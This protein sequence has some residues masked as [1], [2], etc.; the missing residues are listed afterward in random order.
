MEPWVKVSQVPEEHTPGE[1]PREYAQRLAQS[2]GRAVRQGLTEAE[3]ASGPAW[4]L[5]ADTVVVRGAHLLEKPSDEEDARRILRAL[6]GGWHEVVTAFWLGSVGGEVERL[7]FGA[8]RVQFREMDED[9]VARYVATGEPMDKAGAYG[10]QG[11]AGAFVS[12]I[13]GSYFNVVGLPT[14]QVISALKEAGAL[15][16]FPFLPRGATP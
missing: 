14:D 13:E 3:R 2:K 15:G 1:A 11:L 10:I 6:S 5:A 9:E 7:G 12:R 4:I 16:P 8:T